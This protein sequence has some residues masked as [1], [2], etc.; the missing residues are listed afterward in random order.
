MITDEE[1][2]TAK[3]ALK[4]A[5]AHPDAFSADDL[6]E[7]ST[8]VEGYKTQSGSGVVSETGPEIGP[9][10]VAQQEARERRQK[11]KQAGERALA[12]HPELAKALQATGLP[13]GMP[14]Q[15][16]RRS[17]FAREVQDK[18]LPSASGNK[19]LYRPP[20][21]TGP[22]S[23]GAFPETPSADKPAPIGSAKG[24]KTTVFYE[25]SVDEFREE[26]ASI[27]GDKVKGF[28]KGSKEYRAYADKK[29]MEAYDNA[30]K[31]GLSIVRAEYVPNDKLR[32]ELLTARNVGGAFVGA[33]DAATAGLASKVA[34]GSPEERERMKSLQERA[35]GAVTAPA[36][37]A[38]SLANPLFRLIPGP[39][40]GTGFLRGVGR[41]ALQG[42]V[43]AGATTGVESA[44]DEV[45]LEEA[46]KRVGMSFGL[47]A[48]LGGL[49]GLVTE[50]SRIHG[51]NLRKTTALGDLEKRGART[52]VRKGIVPGPVLA[53]EERAA[54]EAG[55]ID[56]VTRQPDVA[57]YHAAN[58][59]E[60][61]TTAARREQGLGEQRAAEAKQK[62]YDL[63]ANQKTISAQPFVDKLE[64]VRD[65]LLDETGR[66]RSPVAERQVVAID[67]WLETSR[68]QG[69]KY[70]LS[71]GA[72]KDFTPREVDQLIQD[73]QSYDP[74][75][76][77]Q[78]VP[79]AAKEPLPE[80]NAL[81]KTLHE[82]RDQIAGG[83]EDVPEGL[84]AE[85]TDK[86]GRSRTVRD[87]SAYQ[88]GLAEDQATAARQRVMAGLPEGEVPER[89]SGNQSKQ[90]Q[91]T[92]R[93]YGKGGEGD[94]ALER[95]AGKERLEPIKSANQLRDL[96][97]A[98]AMEWR[99]RMYGLLPVPLGTT[100]SKGLRLR[101]D[102]AL[103]K[104]SRAPNLGFGAPIAEP[105]T[106]RL[107]LGGRTEDELT[108]DQISAIL[109][110]RPPL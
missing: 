49:G 93:N 62:I 53:A 66:P 11:E 86:Q 10:T 60:A 19:E 92:A 63:P 24:G 40:A 74:K 107:R 42:G 69:G 103:R 15:E 82:M 73:L 77:A 89:L 43:G 65:S 95:F 106:R 23:L 27:Y 48:G 57:A 70:S 3:K 101:L 12:E 56:P 41:R 67:K 13:I 17:R 90:F 38:G 61:A 54:A 25:P 80:Y 87:Y 59:E 98:S 7:F 28:D 18:N 81:K 5:I 88:H 36:E 51:E 76:V 31:Q 79:G 68:A 4:H 1:Y 37:L 64:E 110:A 100:S 6:D 22:N 58:A 21:F 102:P 34:A 75:A 20:E 72:P 46:A 16:A 26:T 55:Y 99:L 96:R 105:E 33:A 39:G 9:P 94:Q 30:E 85:I 104:L 35:P 32:S 71:R 29:Y 97:D 52:S 44:V 108:I 2:Q 8:I 83:T 47:G 84:E 50:G 109:A 14:L 78:G 91:G 45:P